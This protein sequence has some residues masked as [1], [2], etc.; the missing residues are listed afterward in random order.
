MGAIRVRVI[1]NTVACVN[2]DVLWLTHA[3]AVA[4]NENNKLT[5]KK[6]SKSQQVWVSEARSGFVASF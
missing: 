4:R 3:E 5:K 1:S 6:K 2:S